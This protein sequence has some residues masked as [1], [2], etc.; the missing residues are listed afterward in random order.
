MGRKKKSRDYENMDIPFNELA[1]PRF[2]GERKRYRERYDKE[3]EPEP[4][5]PDKGWID[6]WV[7]PADSYWHDYTEE[8]I[9]EKRKKMNEALLKEHKECLHK[10][11]LEAI[12]WRRTHNDDE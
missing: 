10:Q 12:E 2:K 5:D 3:F 6:D 11:L 9:K 8:E 1:R 7:D 4:A